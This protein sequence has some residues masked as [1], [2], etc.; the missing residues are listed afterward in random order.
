MWQASPIFAMVILVE[1]LISNYQERKVYTWKE[2]ITNFYLSLLN[3]G[4]DLA[5]RSGYFLVMVYCY[6]HRIFQI[7]RG[8]WYWAGLVIGLDLLFYLLHRMEHYTRLFWAVHVTH[9]SSE[10]M[11]FTV[12][13]RAS[14]FQP[15]YRFLFFIPLVFA[16]FKPIDILFVYSLTMFWTLFVHTE[17]IG[18][19]GWME[20]IFV[21]PSHHRVHH[22]SNEKYLDKNMGQLFI[23][24]DRMFGTFQEEL[25]AEEYE[26][27]R[28]GLTK[29]LE[30][31]GPINIIFHEWK[32]LGRDLS[33]HDLDLKDKINVL[34]KP[35]GWKP[36]AERPKAGQ[37]VDR[38]ERPKAGQ[39]VE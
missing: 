15:L 2:T 10:K 19:L 6:N 35:P 32:E 7:E 9:H 39:N 24:W 30:S 26:P 37:N 14:V 18:K 20:Y 29:P 4:L 13:F 38:A 12:A 8:F 11:N 1:I 36:R 22:A 21:T 17:F 16:G 5:I 27:I 23:I 34:V 25:P 31:R 3:G 28:Y 33:R